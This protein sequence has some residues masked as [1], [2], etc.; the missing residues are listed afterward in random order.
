[1]DS[2]VQL[3]VSCR[4]VRDKTI[5]HLVD[6]EYWNDSRVF[7]LYIVNILSSKNKSLSL[8]FNA[9]FTEDEIHFILSAFSFKN[10]LQLLS[11]LVLNFFQVKTHI[12]S[13]VGFA[14]S[15]F[16]VNIIAMPFTRVF[17][18]VFVRMVS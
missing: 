9:S 16:R 15:G 6:F 14:T 13:E 7:S 12:N 11:L 2:I 5:L 18:D 4:V 3:V 8:T 17:H 1:M 10:L